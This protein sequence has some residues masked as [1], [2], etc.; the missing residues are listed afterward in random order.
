MGMIGLVSGV[1]RDL[2][3]A[4][5]VAAFPVSAIL[6]RKRRTAGP[7]PARDR[8]R[9]SAGSWAWRASASC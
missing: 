4:T 9:R 2:G 1:V 8:L 6:L 3:A 5:V 7:L